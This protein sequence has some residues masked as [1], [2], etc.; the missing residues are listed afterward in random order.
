M[1]SGVTK[2]MKVRFALPVKA[3]D[4]PEVWFT[5]EEDE[6]A[7]QMDADETYEVVWMLSTE[8]HF[9]VDNNTGDIVR[10]GLCKSESRD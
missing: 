5:E 9:I 2:P 6:D 7:L 10:L 1:A 3:E 4:P 8:D